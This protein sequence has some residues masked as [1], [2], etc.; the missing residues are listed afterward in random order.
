M[1]AFLYLHVIEIHKH[2]IKEKASNTNQ[3]KRIYLNI[4]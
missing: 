4:I 1:R 2:I 3:K